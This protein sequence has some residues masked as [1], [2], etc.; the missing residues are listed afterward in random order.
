MSVQPVLT[1][2]AGVER[3]GHLIAVTKKKKMSKEGVTTKI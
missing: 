1:P 3:E 2:F